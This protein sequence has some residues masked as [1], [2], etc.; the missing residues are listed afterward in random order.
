[1]VVVQEEEIKQEN[2]EQRVWGE[3]LFLARN[4]WL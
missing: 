1:M 2:K 3:K 4:K